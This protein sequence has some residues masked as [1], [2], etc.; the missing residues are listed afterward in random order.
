MRLGDHKKFTVRFTRSQLDA[1]TKVSPVILNCN[2]KYCRDFNFSL[3][4]RDTFIISFQ[5][6]I[7]EF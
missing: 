5:I 2:T 3:E 4:K 7:E 6:I 1:I